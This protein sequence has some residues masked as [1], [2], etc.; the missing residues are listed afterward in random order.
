MTKKWFDLD[1]P[2]VEEMPNNAWIGNAIIEPKLQLI[3]NNQPHQKQM[4][5]K[6]HA[7][8]SAKLFLFAPKK[9]YNY[10]VRPHIYNF[11]SSNEALTNM[12]NN[13]NADR[14]LVNN[15]NTQVMP[16]MLDMIR[17]MV[18]G[19]HIVNLQG[20]SQMWT[21]VLI[22]DTRS[23]TGYTAAMVAPSF[24]HICTGFCID[25]P[26][27]PITRTPN[28]SAEFKFCHHTQFQ[29]REN[30]FGVMSDPQVVSNHDVIPSE[31]IQAGY[32]VGAAFTT[33]TPTNM[34]ATGPYMHAL[35]QFGGNQGSMVLAP[36]LTQGTNPKVDAS[37]KLGKQHLQ[38]LSKFML[39]AKEQTGEYSRKDPYG[40]PN[41]VAGEDFATAFYNLLTS[42][43]MVTA[44][45]FGVYEMLQFAQIDYM[46]PELQVVP[47]MTTNPRNWEV[48]P[49]DIQDNLNLNFYNAWISDSIAF[50][51]EM[52]GLTNFSF[53][54]D[55]YC[56][57]QFE[58]EGR[59]VVHKLESIHGDD[60]A[61]TLKCFDDVKNKLEM[62]LFSAIRF[63]AGEFVLNINY[64][65][66]AET[67]IELIF[68]DAASSPHAIY[69]HPTQLGGWVNPNVG[70]VGTYQ[71]NADQLQSVVNLF[72]NL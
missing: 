66:A 50:I 59:W 2:Q 17:P 37:L 35:N 69:E 16:Q 40:I 55:S 9:M 53:T 26:I 39:A 6:D 23:L 19:G 63:S 13:F 72:N 52:T 64:R 60:R 56:G 20:I 71:N 46:L 45:G 25:E 24:R 70:D 31:F 58:R 29:Y 68:K 48:Y 12:V 49:S 10:Q 5:G 57:N 4:M 51:C 34:Q 54:Y 15:I 41:P 44:T 3:G 14:P 67:L 1:S 22:V 61:K 36:T 8:L 42:N 47:I 7:V 30:R 33:L 27:N 18:S 28:M 43:N 38:T 32:N 65:Y 21:F 11:K 62:D